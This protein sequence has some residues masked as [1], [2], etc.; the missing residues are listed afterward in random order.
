M[1]MLDGPWLLARDPDNIGRQQRWYAAAIL[2]DA[3]PA[4]VPGIIQQAF[5]GYHG[6]AWYTCS[7]VPPPLPDPDGRYLLR[8]GAV[9]YLADLWVNGVYI[10][11]HEGGETPFIL[12]ATQ[13]IVPDAA[14][15]LTVRV[16]NPTHEPIDGIVLNQTPHRNKYIPFLN[17]GSWDYGGI[18]EPVELLV[19]PAIWIEDLHVRPAWQSGQVRVGAN[20]RNTSS[21]VR[22]ARLRVA[23]RAAR[24]P[25]TLAASEE[26]S[27]D[28]PPGDTLCA[29][30]L[31]VP[32]HR[33]WDVSDPVLYYA[34]AH[35][36]GE[37]SPALDARA[38]RFG[39]RDFRVVD[40]YFRLNGRRIFVRSTHT[41]NHSPLAQILAPA[42]APDLLRRD[43]IYAKAAGFNMVRFIAGIAHPDQLDLAD[44]LGLLVYEETLAAW[45]L[46]D[47]PQMAER[48]DRS[49][50]EMILRDRNHPSVVIW[51]LLNETPDGPVFRHAAAALPLVRALDDS[52]LVLL[53]SGR[54]D[55]QLAI[56][57]VSNPGSLAWEHMWGG[58]EPD[59]APAPYDWTLGYPGGYFR[60]VGD[61]HTYPRMPHTPETR[62][63][64]RTLG[65]DTRPVF[66]SEYG[67][68]SVMNVLREL[69]CYEQA[70]A[71]PEAEDVALMRAMAE[72]FLADWQRFGMDDA[73][74][75]PEDMLRASQHLHAHQ[76]RLG[77]DLIRANPHL[78]GFNLT[79][80]LDH[81][82]T[83]EG[84]WTFWR[85][86]K[87]GIVD[88]LADGW[89][90]L[91]W[92]LFVEPAHTYVGQPITLEAVLAN[93]DVLPP[94][95]YP[96]TLRVCGPAGIVWETKIVAPI[97]TPAAGQDGPLA[98]PVFRE[99]VR[100]DGPA[101]IYIFA[102]QLE[103]GGAP[104]GGQLRFFLSDPSALPRLSQ[105]VT[106]WGVDDSAASWLAARGA[107]LRPFAAGVA[108]LTG[109]GPEVILVGD[110][111][112]TTAD[113]ESYRELERRVAAGGVAVFLTPAALRRNEDAV[114]WLPLAQ[115]GRGYEFN[116]WLYHKE[117]V[118][119]RHAVFD[120]LPA[121][122]I[123][124][125]DYYGPV[126]S[127]FLFEGQEPLLDVAAAAF[128]LGYPTPG[129]YA[130]GV[131]LAAY[132]SGAGQVILNAFH[133][134]EN[135]NRQPAADRLLLN[136]IRYAASR[137][138]RS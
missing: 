56:G 135:I 126:L 3:R 34:E 48:F 13:A 95:D 37:D 30:D 101:G 98:V 59:A 68:G 79:G 111:T 52:R 51:G 124:E 97:P 125:W 87:P 134:L 64:L 62:R 93:E 131:Q 16:L 123:L 117:S 32:H 133:L 63:F 49:L 7:F 83:G 53:N 36:Q 102:A 19:M 11:S 121:P 72:R 137:T 25:G 115:K 89:A 55:C 113:P 44:E 136:L 67:I 138:R 114:G 73:Y 27:I 109:A 112:Q 54:W 78:C 61:A 23:I 107:S 58:E 29:L 130:S 127:P 5:P 119:R 85:E 105:Q 116:D 100:L 106:T 74:P 108:S 21:T 96:V 14:N 15:R 33:L 24:S 26:R 47:S 46:E 18:T 92:C 128:A 118:A 2:P 66:L 120:G 28:L 43:L 70:G 132:A 99:E 9:D 71:D 41:G 103:R 81:G 91:R 35:V 88:A 10:G 8:C 122:G 6:V 42:T 76:R 17:G 129:G 104:T 1:T 60:A 20:L 84:L 39:F 77:F 69:R 110:L 80:M 90:P 82:M 86:W 38:T 12:D 22:R 40:G 94:G 45:L 31:T 4:P 57:S 65:H 75:F 50:R